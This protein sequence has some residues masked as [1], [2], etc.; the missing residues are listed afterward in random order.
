MWSRGGGERT[1]D[2]NGRSIRTSFEE[3]YQVVHDANTTENEILSASGIPQ[4]K[5]IHPDTSYLA[6]TKVGKRQ[7]AGL[8]MSYVP[9][10]YTGIANAVGGDDPTLMPPVWEWNDVTSQEPIDTDGDGFPFTNVNGEVVTGITDDVAD[11]VLTITRNF[12]S[13]NT[14]GFRQYKRAVNSDFYGIGG[15]IWPPGTGWLQQCRVKNIFP[16]QPNEY[17]EVTT[18]M[19]FREPYL[20]SAS[21]AWWAR[22][23]NEGYYE[24]LGTQITFS[25]GGGAGAL[26]YAIT[27]TSGAITKI[28][29]ANGGSGYTAAPTVNIASTTGGT[30]A[31]ATAT[32]AG[33]RVTS[34][35]VGA[36]GSSYKSRLVRA[37]DDNKQTVNR[38]VLL[39]ATGEREPDASAAVW[40]ERKKK[41]FALP[42]A[43]LGML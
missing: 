7:P 6:V 40:L 12:K 22:Y 28:V 37:T 15:S 42:F 31:T 41:P 1:L 27:N 2:A 17:V 43:A 19:L 38:P 32:V 11:W 24:R 36:G 13:F 33:G 10:L 34:V 20:T 25:G 8:L 5:D 39:K 14:Y 23:R 21:R 35:S 18:R 3:V 29:I 9:V 4:E 30:G 16:G 26:A